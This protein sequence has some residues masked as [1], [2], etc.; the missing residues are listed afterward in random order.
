MKLSSICECAR[1]GAIG[2]VRRPPE[3]RPADRERDPS[4][5]SCAARWLMC[6]IDKS[7]S[8]ELVNRHG[9]VVDMIVR[10]KQPFD[11]QLRV[12]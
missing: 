3:G 12:F 4:N 11:D 5:M 8:P 1:R 6:V 10:R 2:R 9:A 7:H